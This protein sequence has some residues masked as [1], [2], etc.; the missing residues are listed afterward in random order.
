[1]RCERL[2]PTTVIGQSD[3]AAANAATN[4]L[5]GADLCVWLQTVACGLLEM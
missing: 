2:V 3:C 1:V 5:A 4:V